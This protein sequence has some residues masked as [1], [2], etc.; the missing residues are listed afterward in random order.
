VGW[1]KYPIC[2]YYLIEKLIVFNTIVDG[3]YISTASF[4]RSL[5]DIFPNV[6]LVIVLEGQFV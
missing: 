4:R 1:H 5:K 2:H 6:C 3:I